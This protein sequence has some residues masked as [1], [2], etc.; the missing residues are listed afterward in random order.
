MRIEVDELEYYRS[1]DL[2]TAVVRYGSPDGSLFWQWASNIASKVDIV[3]H[4]QT[5]T[6]R[7]GESERWSDITPAAIRRTLEVR[8]RLAEFPPSMPVPL[9][10][11]LSAIPAADRYAID[12][13]IAS[14]IADSRG[15]L[16]HAGSMPADVE[17]FARLEPSFLAVGIDTLTGVTFDLC[18]PTPQ[19]Y[20]VS[21]LYALARLFRRKRLLRQAEGLALLL[22]E[23]ELAYHDQEFAFDACAALARDL[24]ALVRLA[25][26]NGLHDQ[27][28]MLHPLIA[29]T[30]VKT[31]QDDQSRSAAMDAFFE[32]SLAAA[33]DVNSSSEAAAHYSIGNFYRNQHSLARAAYRYNRARHLRPAYLQAGYFFRELAGVLFLAGHFVLARRFYREAVRLDPYDADLAFLLGDALLFSGAVAE[34]HAHFEATI[35]HCTI[36]RLL[37]EAKLKILMCDHLTVATGSMTVPRRRDEANHAMRRDGR[38]SAEHLEDL[39]RKVDAFNPLARFNLGIIRAHEGN[40]VAALHHFLAC[41]L[42]QPQDIAAWANAAIC[43]LG[44]DDEELLLRILSTAIHHMGADAYDHFRTDIAAQG[45]APERLA[46]LDEKAMQFLKESEGSRNDSLTLRM[47]DGDGYQTM[48]IL[49]RGNT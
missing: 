3:E 12:R 47:L 15:A 42:I 41:A 17:A 14:A 46:L 1:L 23:R 20:L 10:V 29:L 16:V 18:D 4:Q 30:I 24:P 2:P 34:A 21:I 43:A 39:L 45:A 5:V 11:D 26:I 31:P 40:R 8:R 32:A 35:A 48:T 36:P 22:T 19:D 7:F 38:N 37:R 27:G 44:L 49:G 13:M 6:Y 28:S 9:R 25:I 33:R